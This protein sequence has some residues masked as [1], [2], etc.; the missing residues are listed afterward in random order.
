[1]LTQ[2]SLT[3]FVFFDCRSLTIS[4]SSLSLKL[5]NLF[6]GGS[7]KMP[8]NRS[9][10]GLSVSSSVNCEDSFA[11]LAEGSRTLLWKQCL[12]KDLLCKH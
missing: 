8:S 5:A 9:K 6:A 7:G 3:S 2:T 4:L 10:D 12:S 1:M 11:F